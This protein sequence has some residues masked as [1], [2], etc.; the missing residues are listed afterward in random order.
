MRKATLTRYLHMSDDEGTFGKLVLDNGYTCYTGELPWR[1][2][3]HDLSC[4]MPGPEDVPMQYVCKLT[5]SPKHGRNLYLVTGTPDRNSVEIHIGNW[6]GDVMKGY[7][8]D[9]LGCIIVGDMVQDTVPIGLKPQRSVVHSTATLTSFMSQ[10][11]GE[12][13]MLAISWEP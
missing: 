12:D 8:S 10:L 5:W 13:F 9:V 11:D 7:K 3:H 2:N 6:C 4:V 1:D